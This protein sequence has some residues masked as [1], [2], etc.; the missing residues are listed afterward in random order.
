MTVKMRI[1]FYICFATTLSA[2]GGGDDSANDVDAVID[3]TSFGGIRTDATELSDQYI[4]T[5]GTLAIA[6]SLES[7]LPVTGSAVYSGFAI[8]SMTGPVMIGQLS[9]EADFATASING[10][11]WN[12]IHEINGAYT[13]MLTADGLLTPGATSAIPQI[14]ATLEGTL[15]NNNQFFPTTIALEGYFLGAEYLA[16]SGNADGFVGDEFISG[17]FAAEQ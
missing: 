2:C 17:I 4:S 11:A 14:S 10:T 15:Q 12:F 16:I 1:Y 6:T 3:Y 9:I 5:N 8:A 7:D 13:G